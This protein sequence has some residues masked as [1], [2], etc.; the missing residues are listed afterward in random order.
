MKID[1]DG[2][3]D[4]VVRI[5]LSPENYFGIQA[6]DKGIL[7]IQGPAFFYGREPAGEVAIKV[8]SFEDRESKEIV[9]GVQDATVSDDGSKVLVNQ[10]GGYKL[11]DTAPGGDPK[12]VS[13][14]DLQV[15]RDPKAEWAEIFDE[16]WRRYRDFF[17]VPNMHG[18][19]W[20]ALGDQYRGLLQY[21]GHRSDLNYVI[22]EMIAELSIS[23][24]YIAGGDYEIPERP[25]V[26]LP[27]A[28]FALD[29]ASGRY[30]ISKIFH[31][32]NDEPRYRSPLEEVGVDVHEGD[33]V[34]AIDG[35]QLEAS[36]NPYRML[37]YKAD[38]PVELTVNDKPTMD[39]ARTVSYE[40]ITDEDKLIYLE[41]VDGNMDKVAE[42]SD[43]TVGYIHVPDM[44]ADGIWEFI[45]HYYG[46][47]DK[48][49][50]IIDVRNNGGGN[51]SGMLIER[52]QRKLLS[53]G[54]SRNEDFPTT[55]PG[56]AV[57]HGHL[58]CLINENSASDGD[59]FPAMFRQAGL[60]PLIGK[61]TWG[62]V[63][64][65]SGRG[66]LIDGGTVFVPEFGH[67]SVDGTWSIEGWGVEPDIE[68]DQTPKALIEGR[69]PQLEKAIEVIEQEIRDDPMKLPERP[70]PPVKTPGHNPPPTGP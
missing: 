60:G 15:F 30:K 31:G 56:G 21:V 64:G 20:K 50:L 47:L 51:V 24:A 23:H 41:W 39:G 13:T 63:T 61:R 49:G 43:G 52:L 27:G 46:Q 58:V 14:A 65:I 5:P 67:V 18:Y 9:S 7:Y 8:Y 45:K 26:A 62:G 57:F 6:L 42:A 53:V 35:E 29:Q 22:S 25:A 32:E 33:Y 54:Y 2:L 12:Q 10:A 66:P 11:Y 3:A 48:Q 40:P 68:V 59:I 28:R 70:E 44:G 19:D 17:Y 1:W 36:D 69:D 38:R 37:R 4:R 55:Y 16:V 34:L